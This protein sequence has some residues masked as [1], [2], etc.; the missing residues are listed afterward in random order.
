[1]A[2]GIV[3]SHP[4]LMKTEVLSGECVDKLEIVRKQF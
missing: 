3:T 1:M 2:E 4:L